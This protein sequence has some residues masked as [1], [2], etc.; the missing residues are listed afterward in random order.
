MTPRSGWESLKEIH[1]A[2]RTN[3]PD[4]ASLSVELVN[5]R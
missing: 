4:G 1:I 3:I 5:P 2:V